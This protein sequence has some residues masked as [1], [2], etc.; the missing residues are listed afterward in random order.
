MDE[1]RKAAWIGGSV[2][3]TG[4]VVATEDLVIDGQVRGTIEI[5]DHSLTIGRDASVV[6]N[7]AARNVTISGRVQGNVTGS[8][9]VELKS[10]ATVQGDVTAPKFTMEEGAAL[11]GTVEMGLR[12]STGS[13]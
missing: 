2:L 12:G 5:G 7:L 13:K 3:V 6:A 8:A 11:M 1:R 9:R 10:S 4:D